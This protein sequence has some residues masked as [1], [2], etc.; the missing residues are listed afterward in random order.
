MKIKETVYG[1]PAKQILATPDHYVAIARKI[2]QNSPL[3]RD[4]DGRKIIMEGTVFP[5]NDETAIG[6]VLNRYDVTDS[7][8]NAA[9]VV[10]GFIQTS[11]LPVEVNE[12][13]KQALKQI[14]FL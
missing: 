2:E 6:I 14:S 4:E 13:A 11:K 10:H 7:Y 12:N 1:E 8:V 9:I 5:A 3:A